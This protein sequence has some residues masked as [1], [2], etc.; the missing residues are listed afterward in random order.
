MTAL[1]FVLTEEIVWIA[2]DTLSLTTGG[3]PFKYVSKIFPLPHLS[4][5]M[6]GTGNMNVIVDWFAQIQTNVVARSFIYLNTVG[7]EQL[8]TIEAKYEHLKAGT[9]TIYHFGYDEDEDRFRGFAL[10]S[11]RDY[12]VEQL[13]YG[14]GIKP[15]GEEL[16]A[17]LSAGGI[18]T[19]GPELFVR[20]MQ[21]LKR[22]DDAL[23]PPERLGVGGEIHVLRLN[24]DGQFLWRC[25]R[26]PDYEA[27]FTEMLARLQS[28]N[29]DA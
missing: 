4:G 19:P 24:G 5:A 6:A 13:G 21:D 12:A 11:P 17:G 29:E 23:P 25:H 26:F 20:L 16:V 28:E 22:R 9:T 18:G 14:L 10:R 2:T 1:I 8:R 7:P 15:Y 27:V 3:S